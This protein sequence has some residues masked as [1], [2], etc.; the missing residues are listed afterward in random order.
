MFDLCMSL[1]GL[2]G[3]VQAHHSSST[4][5]LQLP[6]YQPVQFITWTVLIIYSLRL[7]SFSQGCCSCRWHAILLPPASFLL[8]GISIH[9]FEA[10]DGG[11]LNL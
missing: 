5:Y 9:W 8:Y 11:S 1:R 3:G 7:D 10:Q 2:E 4:L 6:K